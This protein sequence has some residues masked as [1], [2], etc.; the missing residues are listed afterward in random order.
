MVEE[1]MRV[2]LADFQEIAHP[3][4]INIYPNVEHLL[5]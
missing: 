3:A 1:A 2:C 5:S 4:S